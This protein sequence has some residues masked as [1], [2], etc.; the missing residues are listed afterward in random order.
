MIEGIE[1]HDILR[2]EELGIDT[3][4]GG[5]RCTCCENVLQRAAI[6]RMDFTSEV[7]RVFRPS[8]ERPER[9]RH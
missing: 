3:C 9:S 1:N 6:D 2:V 8:G 7:V 5:F 4:P